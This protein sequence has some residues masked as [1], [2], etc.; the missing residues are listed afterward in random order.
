[1]GE[2]AIQTEF[3]RAVLEVGDNARRCIT[4]RTQILRQSGILRPERSAQFASSSWGQ[5]PVNMLA[6]EGR[7]HGAVVRAMSKR[8]A[9]LANE[10]SVGLVGRW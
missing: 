8:I 5:R 3:G 9:R 7:V 4:A 1:M 6:C 2:S 10:S